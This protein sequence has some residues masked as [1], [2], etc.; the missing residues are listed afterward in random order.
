MF[1]EILPSIIAS[2]NL[3]LRIVVN[4][5]MECKVLFYS[6]NSIHVL[7]ASL[8]V[9]TSSTIYIYRLDYYISLVFGLILDSKRTS[10]D[11]SLKI[12]VSCDMKCKILLYSR[13]S[14]PVL[15][16]SHIYTTLLF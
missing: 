4:N 12:V 11:P 5:V 9:V 7:I 10:Y 2:Y 14:I 6:W 3:I 1:G 15:I 8:V 16:T 13:K